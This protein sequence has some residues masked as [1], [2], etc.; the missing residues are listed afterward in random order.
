MVPTPTIVVNPL[1]DEA[2]S[3]ALVPNHGHSVNE[4][5]VTLVEPFELAP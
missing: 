2:G 3:L 4:D 1:F 5:P